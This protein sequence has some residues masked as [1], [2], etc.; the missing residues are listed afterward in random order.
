[1]A[2]SITCLIAIEEERE[3]MS[4]R[5]YTARLVETI[6][7]AGLVSCD[8]KHYALERLDLTRGKPTLQLRGGLTVSAAEVRASHRAELRVLDKGGVPVRCTITG[9]DP[10]TE[11]VPAGTSVTVVARLIREDA[12]VALARWLDGDGLRYG[13]F[14]NG[15]LG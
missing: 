7:P 6:R 4:L 3:L 9:D 10:R 8:G 13:V 2:G 5:P 14:A 11:M 1:V 15:D 12:L